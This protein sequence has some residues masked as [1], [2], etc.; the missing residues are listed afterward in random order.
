MDVTLENLMFR[1]SHL[2]ETMFDHLDNQS[3]VNCKFVSKE[4]NAYLSQQKFHQIRIIK[5]TVSKFQELRQPW[6]D[7]FKTA[8]KRTIMMLGYAVDQFYT[9]SNYLNYNG[10]TPLHVAAGTNNGSLFDMISEKAQDKEP[11]EDTGFRPIAFAVQNG[12]LEMTKA[13]MK[14]SEDKN[15]KATSGITLLHLAA[16]DGRFEIFKMIFEEVEDKNPKDGT[17]WTPLHAAAAFGQMN[18][19]EMIID[20]VKEKKPKDYTYV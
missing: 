1:F 14:K 20:Y 17:G 9:G 6:I 12:H 15:P 19:F 8:N 13:I 7:V 3:L 10:I 5:E 11:I 2:S 4:L 18:I 16:T